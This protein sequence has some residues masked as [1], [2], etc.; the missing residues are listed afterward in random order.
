MTYQL[1]EFC[2]D[3]HDILSAAPGA[4]GREKVRQG[5]ERLLANADFVARYLGPDARPGRRVLHHDP[6]TGIYVLGHGTD[7]Y[8]R[9]G[10]PH[11]HG[12]SWAIY[13][14]AAGVTNMTVWRRTD[15]GS[16]NGHAELEAERKFTLEPGVV[17]MFGPHVIHSTAHPRPARYVRITGTDLDSIERFRFDLENHRVTVEN[18]DA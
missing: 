11:D 14:Q 5:L 4:D 16:R 1:D 9:V 2:R 13:G 17:A 3:A 18:A 10:T 7:Q 8:D 12:A 6:D 15:D